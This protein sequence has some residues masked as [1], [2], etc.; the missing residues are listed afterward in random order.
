MR[1]NR[2]A[3]LLVLFVFCCDPGALMAIEEPEY[4]V[5]KS[6]DAYELREYAPVVAIETEVATDFE[7][8]GNRAF[9]R[10]FNYIDGQNQS[11]TKIAMTAPVTQAATSEKI[12]MTAPVTQAERDGQYVIRFILPA[13]YTLESAPTPLD[14]QVKLAAVPARRF[15]VIRYSGT[16]SESNYAEALAELKA[17]LDRDG[18][19][20]S[21]EPIW[22]RYNSPFSLWFLRRNEVWLPL[23][24]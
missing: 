6:A 12:S 7:E 22:A 21:D 15:A 23:R 24:P 13:K 20:Y 5:L 16:W 11:K 19:V 10:L 9:R 14:P 18:V 2:Y 3:Y 8:A 1:T 17:A 4:T